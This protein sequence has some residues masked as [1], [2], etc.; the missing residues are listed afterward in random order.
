M[1]C[2]TDCVATSG[3]CCVLEEQTPSDDFPLGYTP[4]TLPGTDSELSYPCVRILFPES[5]VGKINYLVV[6]VRNNFQ[7]KIQCTTVMPGVTGGA[8]G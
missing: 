6:A 4:Y 5:A 2:A 8:G 1:G 3:S 7:C